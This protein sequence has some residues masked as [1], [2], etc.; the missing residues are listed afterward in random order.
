[1]RHYHQ[2]VV[3]VACAVVALPS[4][5]LLDRAASLTPGSVR[6]SA[7]FSGEAR[8]DVAVVLSNSGFSQRSAG[9]G[10][11][12]IDGL[13]G[14]NHGLRLQEDDDNDGVVDRG[15]AVSF[16]LGEFNGG[17]DGVDLGPV[18][19]RG[20]VTVSGT[21][22][23]EDGGGLDGLVVLV[24]RFSLDHTAEVTVPLT[25]D[26]GDGSV[27]FSL[28][29]VVPG[30]IEVQAIARGG[31]AS[32]ATAITLTDD[33]NADDVALAVRGV[34]AVAVNTTVTPSLPSAR[35]AIVVPDS[36]PNAPQVNGGNVG[37]DVSVPAG[38][39]DVWFFDG[40][41]TVPLAFLPRQ[42][43]R[44]INGDDRAPLVW[45]PAVRGP[46]SGISGDEN[47]VPTVAVT[48]S[49]TRLL[50]TRDNVVN[51]FNADSGHLLAFSVS[52]PDGDDVVVTAVQPATAPLDVFVNND[53][54]LGVRLRNVSAAEA[55][56]AIFSRTPVQ[57]SLDD[58][59]DEP[60]IVTIGTAIIADGVFIGGVTNDETAMSNDG[61]WLAGATSIS[62]QDIV[63]E[64]PADTTGDQDFHDID[65]RSSIDLATGR[66]S[67]TSVFAGARDA[68]I[69]GNGQVLLEGTI[70]DPAVLNGRVQDCD[71][72]V[73][74]YAS[75]GAN[76]NIASSAGGSIRFT[77][78]ATLHQ[79]ANVQNVFIQVPFI[80]ESTANFEAEA[81]VFVNFTTD[82]S[83]DGIVDF[84]DAAGMAFGQI[85]TPGTFTLAGAGFNRGVGLAL[86]AGAGGTITVASDVFA[87]TGVK[88]FDGVTIVAVDVDGAPTGTFTTTALL[89]DPSA[90]FRGDIVLGATRAPDAPCSA[91]G[92]VDGNVTATSD[93]RL[94]E[95][96][97]GTFTLAENATVR[98][99]AGARLRTSFLRSAGTI[100]LAGGGTLE[101]L[102]GDDAMLLEEGTTIVSAAP[103]AHEL[104]LIGGALI[105]EDIVSFNST[106]A[107]LA[108]D[109]VRVA[110]GRRWLHRAGEI[111]VVTLVLE[112]G[113]SAVVDSNTPTPILNVET[114]KGAGA[115]DGCPNRP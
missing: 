76:L 58:G 13:S 10:A 103:H 102:G 46:A 19:M 107:A 100:D 108:F 59:H 39:Y 31:R 36:G 47:S 14:G 35:L 56:A 101:L 28:R 95:L 40:D 89:I 88:V 34:P 5:F 72:L 82:V 109:T 62:R 77:P 57:L 92:V 32:D 75:F 106:L 74:G 96:D 97:V 90:T 11:F 93:L 84:D 16:V 17:F 68:L 24:S 15:A 66:L 8:D 45:G 18:A 22:V 41:S 53:D 104:H 27:T 112:A 98:F 38:V 49:D 86:F 51:G 70:D 42:V 67:V 73:D 80:L 20:T 52:D 26:D 7:R 21:I 29:G 113:A 6:G 71:V 110:T 55:D 69:S 83:L 81:G 61:N 78:G 3:V 85:G 9:G 25:D 23:D 111:D 91:T 87:P 60:I 65:L 63:V 33:A 79:F 115:V 94:G 43:A 37:V 1:M 4:C 44:D 99:G 12:L 64:A 2:L 50:V 30:E 54:T 114:C 105:G 48:T